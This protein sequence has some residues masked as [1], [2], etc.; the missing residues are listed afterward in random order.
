MLHSTEGMPHLTESSSFRE[1][2]SAAGDKKVH[3]FLRC[4]LS[5]CLACVDACVG[6]CVHVYTSERACA[7]LCEHT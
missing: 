4:S 5:G 3:P 1:T 6:T 2:I 7:C